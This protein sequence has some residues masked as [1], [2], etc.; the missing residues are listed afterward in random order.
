MNILNKEINIYNYN[1]H[2]YLLEN[3]IFLININKMKIIIIIILNIK[4]FKI[5]S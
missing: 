2:F 4:L 3:S 5:S 1:K